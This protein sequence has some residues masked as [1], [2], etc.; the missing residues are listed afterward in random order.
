[1]SEDVAAY[2]AFNVKTFPH[3]HRDGLL[4]ITSCD[5]DFIVCLNADPKVELGLF[6]CRLH[7]LADKL[8]EPLRLWG[9]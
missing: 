1:V 7:E 4:G 5:S 2:V 9:A 3:R 8:K 6:K